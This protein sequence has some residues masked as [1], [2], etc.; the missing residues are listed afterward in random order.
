MGSKT[1]ELFC[2]NA[3]GVLGQ[4]ESET[5]DAAVFDPPYSTI[6][7][8]SN[9]GKTGK[10]QRPSGVL[11]K[12]DGKIFEHNDIK[13]AAYLPEVYRVLKP[14]AHVYMMTNVLNV[15]QNDVI[16]DLKRAGFQIHNLLFWRK[17]NATP[18]RWYMKDA[19]LTIFARK[20]PA[21]QINNPG[22]R[23][24]LS[25]D[26][27]EDDSRTLWEFSGFDYP[28]DWDNVASPKAHPTEK[29][30]K[31][32]QTYIENSTKEGD[33]VLD[34]FM[35]VGSTGVAAVNLGRRFVGIEI[36]ENYCRTA[37]RRLSTEAVFE[38]ARESI[39]I[40]DLLGGDPGVNEL[41]AGGGGLSVDDLLA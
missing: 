29:P 5:I 15:V 12:N 40:E 6:S 21:F 28:L 31:L 20:G 14:S 16:G 9:Q 3:L 2:G 8:G 25:I 24:T 11:A 33:L 13:P 34:L 26:P 17:N 10:H 35:G 27:H 19:E 1:I 41:L 39:G 36:D 32:M 4:I 22:T 30:V 37:E 7:G 38:T 18:N 23:S